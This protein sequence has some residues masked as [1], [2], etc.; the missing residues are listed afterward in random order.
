[1]KR[2]PWDRNSI[3]LRLTLFMTVLLF[4]QS[5][6]LIGALA[7]GGL[8][9]RT[10]EDA[11]ASLTQKVITPR[12]YLQSEMTSRWSSL[13]PY[14]DQFAEMLPPL[15]AAAQGDAEREERFLTGAMPLLVGMLRATTAS[16][17]FIILDNAGAPDHSSLYLRDYDPTLNDDDNLDLYLVAGPSAV[18]TDWRIPLDKIWKSRMPRA[19]T[20][21][22][23]YNKPMTQAQQGVDPALLG[24]W[25]PPFR[26]TPPDIPI[27]TFTTPLPDADG[28]IRGVMGVEIS[29]YYLQRAL[30][31]VGYRAPSDPSFLLG[32]RPSRDE[33]VRP[34]LASNAALNHFVQSGAPLPDDSSD[35]PS[36]LTDAVTG[37]PYY[38]SAQ[39]L[40][41]Y[42]PNTPFAEEEWSLIGLVPRDNLLEFTLALQR[43]LLWSFLASLAL[44]MACGFAGS[45]H[46]TRPIVDLARR[47][48]ANRPGSAASLGKTGLR[49]IDELAGAI[50]EANRR[51]LDSTV[52]MSAIIEMVNVPIGAFEYREDDPR[53]F[54]TDGLWRILSLNEQ[55]AEELYRDKDLFVRRLGILM[56]RPE[57]EEEYVYKI[58]DAPVKWVRINMASAGGAPLGVA[59]DVSAEIHEKK[60]IRFD[61]DFDSLTRLYNREAFRRRVIA[62]LENGL[63]GVCALAML[64]LDYLKPLNDNF[65][66][67]WGDIYIRT[68]AAL[69]NEFCPGHC[70][71]GRRSGDEFMLFLH[72]FTSRADV[73]EAMDSFYLKL[74]RH[75]LSLPDG[76]RRAIAISAGIAWIESA[77][78]AYDELLQ[79]ADFTLYKAKKTAKG[80]YCIS[81]EDDGERARPMEAD[82]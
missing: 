53:V 59:M 47:V 69:L 13:Y 34:I 25:S 41:L 8:L 2:I 58:Q 38:A 1:M 50:K 64:D 77:D 19:Q 49:E 5:V 78:V 15:A 20:D 81:D 23:F 31:A 21:Q 4:G 24:Y 17:A 73:R 30:P 80:G 28:V 29:L 66:H 32:F 48:R 51:L 9:S 18:S 36:L 37:E 82:A 40:E 7:A 67:A 52:K 44:G 39:S 79:C 16:G 6:L 3:L 14:A 43:I 68:T 61:R 26:L 70:I 56:S 10:R 35:T 62:A 12:N 27:I 57:P 76:T 54:A 63:S 60:T 55:E 75:S 46:V 45:Y 72:G 42:A 74:N 11:F 22:P 71:A 33:A 65:G